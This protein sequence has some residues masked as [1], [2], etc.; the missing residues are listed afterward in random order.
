M[1]R[2]LLIGGTLFCLANVASAQ[3]GNSPAP[4]AL[5]GGK[6]ETKTQKWEFGVSIRAVGGPCAG[7]TGTFPLPA[8]WPEQQVKVATEQITPA[9]KRHSMRE[10]D[11]LSQM[12]F[13]VP[14]LATGE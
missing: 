3:F 14:Q 2:S 9:V 13:E 1:V 12:L 10:A 8:N 5:G 7:L 6:V 4:P 11:G